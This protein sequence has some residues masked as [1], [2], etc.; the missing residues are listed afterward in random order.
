MR[1]FRKVYVTIKT[2][3]ARFVNFARSPHS[4]KLIIENLLQSIYEH[5]N[6]VN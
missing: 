4:L 5:G 6:K 3:T 2:G 1:F